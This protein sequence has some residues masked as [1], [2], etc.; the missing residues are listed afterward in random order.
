MTMQVDW[1]VWLLAI[2]VAAL[3]LGYF[4][5]TGRTIIA[6]FR[7]IAQFIEDWPQTRRAMVEAEARSGGRYPLWFRLARI[8]LV[9]A[10]VALV[11]ILL[12]RRFG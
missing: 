9:L 12:W 10:L 3:F 1:F 6:S 2:A 7:R 4:W 5:W 11:V 8:A